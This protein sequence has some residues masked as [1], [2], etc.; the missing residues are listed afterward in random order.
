D[1]P[2]QLLVPRPIYLSHPACAEGHEDLV[3]TEAGADSERHGV[4]G[5]FFAAG[6]R[7]APIELTIRS[8]AS[9]DSNCRGSNL[10]PASNGLA[11]PVEACRAQLVS[12]QS[13]S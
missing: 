9:D 5:I 7:S 4:A 3:R 1:V 10:S 6:R 11:L 13:C 8:G 12:L 2:I